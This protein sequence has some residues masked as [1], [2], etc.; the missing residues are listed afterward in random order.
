MQIGAGALS[1]FF[2][3]AAGHSSS[4]PFLPNVVGKKWQLPCVKRGQLGTRDGRLGQCCRRYLSGYLSLWKTLR[5]PLPEEG[6]HYAQICRPLGSPRGDPFR[7]QRSEAEIEI[8]KEEATTHEAALALNVH[9]KCRE[10]ASFNY[11][12]ETA[13][14]TAARGPAR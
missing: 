9:R 10:Q 4:L 2:A 5:W 6:F 11:F 7:F 3:M 12:G 14:M 8:K 1:Y 13:E